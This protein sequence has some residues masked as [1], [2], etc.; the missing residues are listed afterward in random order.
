MAEL[1]LLF[2]R[3]ATRPITPQAVMT[4]NPHAFAL[5]TGQPAPITNAA[6]GI[7]PRY[8][9]VVLRAD[10]PVALPPGSNVVIEVA[11]WRLVALPEPLPLAEIERLLGPAKPW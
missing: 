6:L 4:P 5:M 3:T 2:E 7:T 9:H 1:A 11:P 10:R 8:S